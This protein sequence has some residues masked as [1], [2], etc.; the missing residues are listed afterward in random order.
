MERMIVRMV[1][2]KKIAEDVKKTSSSAPLTRSVSRRN[3]FVMA[4]RTAW[5][6]AMRKTVDSAQNAQTVSSSATTTT[7]WTSSWPATG[8]TTAEMEATSTEAS[9]RM[10]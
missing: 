1:V 6:Q 10:S 8:T 3:G 9:V 5:M 4:G 2:M 7:A